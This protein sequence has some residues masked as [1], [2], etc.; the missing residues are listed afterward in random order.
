[1]RNID[2]LLVDDRSVDANVTLF[3][4]R[5]TSTT[6]AKMLRLKNGD[7]ALRFLFALGEFAQRSSAMPGLVLLDMDMPGTS[8]LCVL[9]VIRA[10]PATHALS[11]VMLSTDS[12]PRLPARNGFSADGYLMKSQNRPREL[13]AGREAGRREAG[14]AAAVRAAWGSRAH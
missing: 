11:V 10:H 6:D 14:G 1:M 13:V 3:A 4:L 9:D 12:R 7:E 2:V 8:G 5:Q